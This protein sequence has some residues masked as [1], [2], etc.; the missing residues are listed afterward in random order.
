LRWRK[1]RRHRAAYI[2]CN[3]Q[4]TTMGMRTLQIDTG[5]DT[6]APL[7]TLY[8]SHDAILAGLGE[9]AALPRKASHAQLARRSAAAVLA[10]F[11]G[12]VM[13]HHAD[14]EQDLFPAVLASALPG[15]ERDQVQDFVTRLV[16]E[17]RLL[18]A[19]WNELAP[20]VRKVRKGRAVEIDPAQVT[21][22]VEAYTGHAHLE[23]EQF[24]PL[25]QTILQRDANHLA[26]VGVG[27]HMRRLPDLTGYI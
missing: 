9:L 21:R 22:L 19:L 3:A 4:E 24:L 7:K 8:H 10:L 1:V 17:H 23:E 18:E 14:E 13:Q 5:V 25:A 15:E 20:A 11:E 6:R 26:A 12:D 2:E 16:A 27:L